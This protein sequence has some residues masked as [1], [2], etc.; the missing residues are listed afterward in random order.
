MKKEL[1]YKE[2]GFRIMQLRLDRGYSR[3]RLAE[4]AG[5][6]SKFLFEIERNE[7][8]FSAHTLVNLADAL[9]VSTDYIMTGRGSTKFDEGI[10]ETLEKFEPRILEKVEDLLKLVYEIAHSN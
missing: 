9:D 8:G 6:S 5:I 3:E 1:R 4:V 2:I 10:A 7:K